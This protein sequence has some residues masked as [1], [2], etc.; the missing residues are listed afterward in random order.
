MT[1]PVTRKLAV[2]CLLD[3]VIRQFGKPLLSPVDGQPLLPG[4]AIQ[5]DHI[6]ADVHGGAHEYQNLRPIHIPA[7]KKKTKADI[8]AK[9]KVDRIL[10]ITCNG[11]TKKIQSRGFDKTKTR[12]FNGSVVPRGAE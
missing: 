11:P 5:F 9:A 6:H 2:D 8:Q 1:K 7:H 3:R 12:K 10:G 4:E